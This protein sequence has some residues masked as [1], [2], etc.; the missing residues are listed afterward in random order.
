MRPRFKHARTPTRRDAG[1]ALLLVLIAVAFAASLGTAMILSRGPAAAV[2]SNVRYAGDAR[3]V[4]EAALEIA[5]DMAINDAAFRT[6]Y[7]ND[8]WSADQPFSAGTF[9]VKFADPDDADLADDP[10]EPV[11]ITV[12]AEVEGRTHEVS[13]LFTPPTPRMRFEVGKFTAG[14]N[15]TAVSF[16]STY[17]NPVVVTTVDV[18]N[19]AVARPV[20]VRVQNVTSSGFEAYLQN[21]GDLSTPVADEVYFLAMEAGTHDFDGVMAEAFTMTADTVDRKGSVNAIPATY[22]QTYTE[23]VVLAQV[24]TT[25]D[26]RWSVAWV[27]GNTRQAA[28]NAST[29]RVGRHV[30]EDPDI[31][32]SDETLGVIVFEAG[33]HQIGGVKV[34]AFLSPDM[35][36][37]INTNGNGVYKPNYPEKFNDQAEYAFIQQAG[38]DG[39][40]MG[41][42]VLPDDDPLHSDKHIHVAI[43]EEQI[44]D[45]ERGHTTEQVFVV[46]FEDAPTANTGAGLDVLLVVDDEDSMDSEDQSRVAILQSFGMNVT[47]IDHNYGNPATIAALA[48]ADVVYISPKSKESTLKNI[49]DDLAVPFVNEHIDLIDDLGFANGGFGV[50][51]ERF[52]E[53]VDTSHPITAGFTADEDFRVLDDESDMLNVSGTLASGAQVLADD[54]SEFNDNPVLMTL[55]IGA[56]RWNGIP[57]PSRRVQLPW[58]ESDFDPDEL[59]AQG[60]ELL[61][62]SLIWAA[63]SVSG[64]DPWLTPPRLVWEEP[65]E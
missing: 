62:Q 57:S 51:G 3:A 4:A 12:L 49:I 37:G 56:A 35:V 50:G 40:D 53:L 20:V 16:Q 38:E 60:Q 63:G 11:R 29:L 21:P 17:Q 32:R 65:D 46:A 59:N 55:D 42:A 54:D 2:A 58:G 64:G 30:G 19:N 45:G 7:T 13:A 33:V 14:P 1:Y 41:W 47:L 10:T 25:N 9:Q 44:N 39:G 15:A 6:A 48:A 36:G 52:I 26:S 31:T 43:D 61:R 27:R 18:T 22:Q 34:Q 8:V 24:M 28:P 5:V 23:P